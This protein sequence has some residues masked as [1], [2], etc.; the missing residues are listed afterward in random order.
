MQTLDPR[1][2]SGGYT[3]DAS[4]TSGPRAAILDSIAA[5]EKTADIGGSLKTTEFTAAVAARL[6][7]ALATV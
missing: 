4:P 1:T 6:Q 7:G 2:L 3:E 5:G